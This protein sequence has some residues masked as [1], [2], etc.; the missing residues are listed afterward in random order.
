MSVLSQ[1][2]FY[3]HIRGNRKLRKNSALHLEEVR[4][5]VFAT[6][7]LFNHMLNTDAYFFVVRQ[8]SA[9]YMT[10]SQ[11][12]PRSRTTVATATSCPLR[13]TWILATPQSSIST[14]RKSTALTLSSVWVTAAPENA[15]QG[16][17]GVLIPTIH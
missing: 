7:I 3:G 1:F 4:K 6:T 9:T 14:N 11:I 17:L 2:D 10:K 13:Q 12:L 16:F 8:I 15:P 5:R